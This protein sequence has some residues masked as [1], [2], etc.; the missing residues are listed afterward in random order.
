MSSQILEV[1]R[2]LLRMQF[3]NSNFVQFNKT[4]GRTVKDNALLQ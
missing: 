3:E 4:D 2:Q 1:Y